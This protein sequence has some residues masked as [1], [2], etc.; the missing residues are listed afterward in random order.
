MD[1]AGVTHRDDSI[2]M[3]KQI[4]LTR[5]DFPTPGENGVRELRYTEKALLR[6]VV[7]AGQGPLSSG[8][9]RAARADATMRRSAIMSSLDMSGSTLI[10]TQEFLVA[11]STDMAVKSQFVGHA[12]CAHAALFELKIPWLVDIENKKLVSKYKPTFGRTKQRPDFIGQDDKNRWYVFESKGRVTKPRP[13]NLK[14]WKKQATAI[15]RVNGKQVAQH[16]ISVAHLRRRAKWELLWVDPPVENEIIEFE[17]EDISFFDAY[18]EPIRDLIERESLPVITEDGS[19]YYTPLLDAYVGLHRTILE[20]LEKRD[21][22][23]LRMFASQF[24]NSNIERIDQTAV[25]IFADG[26]MIALPEDLDDEKSH[27]P[28]SD[29][30]PRPGPVSP[31][32]L[33]EF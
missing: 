6:A 8:K 1:D 12:L 7:A 21:P 27:S 31:F 17:F 9:T 4:K 30:K 33:V 14:D 22:N 32:S 15:S 19:L 24:V 23:T 20:A 3:K 26:I 16:I 18:Y 28:K 5:Q 10:P 13:A 2:G 11:G 25:S 29:D